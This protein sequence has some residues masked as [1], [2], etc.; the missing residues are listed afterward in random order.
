M[1]TM[2][3][4]ELFGAIRAEYDELNSLLAS[5]SE[6]QMTESGAQ[7]E[8]SVKDIVAHLTAWQS[9]LGQWLEQARRGETP[10]PANWPEGYIDRLN[11]QFYDENRNRPLADVLADYHRSHERAVAAIDFYSDAELNDPHCFAWWDGE[12]ILTLIEGNTYGHFAEHIAAIR[13]WLGQ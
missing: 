8:W 12:P 9:L 7:D 4:S 5:M 13:R 11:R 10:R 2:N 1:R 3:K 6:A